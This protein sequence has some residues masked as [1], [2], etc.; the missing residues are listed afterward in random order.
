MQLEYLV[1]TLKRH[2]ALFRQREYEQMSTE[3]K[4]MVNNL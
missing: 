2:K 4:N 1:V 3:R